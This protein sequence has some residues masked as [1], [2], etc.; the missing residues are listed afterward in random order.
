MENFKEVFC[1]MVETKAKELLEKEVET[2]IGNLSHIAPGSEEMT[3]AV[4]NVNK[5]Y[6]LKI[7][8]ERLREEAKDKWIKL[9]GDM[10]KLGAVLMFYGTWMRKGFK[11]EEVGSITSSTFR[12]LIGNFKLPKLW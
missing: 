12:S 11:F 9:G 10:A 1:Y 8:D 5:L 3:T 4:E 6:K 7:E 2:Q